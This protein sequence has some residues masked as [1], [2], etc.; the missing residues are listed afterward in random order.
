MQIFFASR[1]HDPHASSKM[2]EK[3]NQ[4]LTLH[5]LDGNPEPVSIENRINAIL[6]TPP[7]N[8]TLQ[9]V[10]R[11]IRSPRFKIRKAAVP[12]SFLVVDGHLV[13]YES[14]NF[15][16]PEQLQLQL[17]IMMTLI[18]DSNS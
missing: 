11:M 18:W 4:G 13:I 7:N 8:E 2:I 15:N 10:K 14:I 16:S 17:L 6:R 12:A 1:Y 3:F 9:L 5:I